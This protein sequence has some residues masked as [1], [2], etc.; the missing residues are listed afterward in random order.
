MENVDYL[1]IIW[2]SK[3]E[4]TKKKDTEDISMLYTIGSFCYSFWKGEKNGDFEPQIRLY[5]YYFCNK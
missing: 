2:G 1:F 4:Y 3:W 5:G